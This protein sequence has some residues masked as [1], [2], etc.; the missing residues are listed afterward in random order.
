MMKS[1]K[2][3]SESDEFSSIMARVFDLV[4]RFSSLGDSKALLWESCKLRS[5]ASPGSM[6][7]MI[8]LTFSCSLSLCFCRSKWNRARLVLFFFFNTKN[9]FLSSASL[10]GLRA[11]LANS[12]GE[13]RDMSLPYFL[14]CSILAMNSIISFCILLSL[15]ASAIVRGARYV[16][17]NEMFCLSRFCTP[18]KSEG[19]I[20]TLLLWL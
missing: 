19:W 9:A 4:L 2:R 3:R 11:L 1:S 7:P 5:A 16:S 14:I 13:S 18:V 20:P 8:Y 10:P 12:T 6:V 15:S 17:G